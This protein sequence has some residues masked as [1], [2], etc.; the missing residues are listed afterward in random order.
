MCLQCNALKRVC[1]KIFGVNAMRIIEREMEKE[2]ES[3][4]QLVTS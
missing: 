3:Q 2:Y 4:F 1:V